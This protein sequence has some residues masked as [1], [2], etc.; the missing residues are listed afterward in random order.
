MQ[1]A[2]VGWVATRMAHAKPIQTRKPFAWVFGLTHANHPYL[3]I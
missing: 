1:L 3:I 2:G